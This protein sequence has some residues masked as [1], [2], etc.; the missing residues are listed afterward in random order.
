M[1]GGSLPSDGVVC[2]PIN[3]MVQARLTRGHAMGR[4]WGVCA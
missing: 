2:G 4:G 3:E 1:I